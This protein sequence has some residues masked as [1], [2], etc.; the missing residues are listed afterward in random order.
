MDVGQFWRS[1][2]GEGMVGD[3]RPVWVFLIERGLDAGSD[4]QL[5]WEEADAIQAAREYLSRSG[6]DANL[7]TGDLVLEAIEAAN[8]ARGAE[9]YVVLAPFP[10]KSSS[11]VVGVAGS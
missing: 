5:F 10:V 11:G 4:L 8:Q 2:H 1:V 6:P 3:E 7:S 9:E